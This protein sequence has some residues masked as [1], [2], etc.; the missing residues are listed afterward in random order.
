M[1]L[2][3]WRTPHDNGRVVVDLPDVFSGIRPE[4]FQI[5]ANLY[6]FQALAVQAAAGPR[7]APLVPYTRLFSSAGDTLGR[8]RHVLQA[9]EQP[10]GMGAVFFPAGGHGHL[11]DEPVH[12]RTRP[13][14]LGRP[15]HRGRDG[16]RRRTRLGPTGGPDPGVTDKAAGFIGFQIPALARH[17]AEVQEK[18]RHDPP[19]IFQ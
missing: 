18:Q 1:S 10:G 2:L 13:P 9:G 6:A 7:L 11:L 4:F 3:A 17:R 5:G 16:P 19:G 15:P 12:G 8:K 14:A